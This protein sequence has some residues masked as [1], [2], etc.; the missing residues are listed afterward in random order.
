MGKKRRRHAARR[1]RKESSVIVIYKFAIYL[2]LV[3]V[4]GGFLLKVATPIISNTA[5]VLGISLLAK[6]GD[7]DSSGSGSS[8]DDS[9]S[10]S[11]SSGSNSD[12]GSS[13][14]GSSSNSSGPSSSQESDS[15]KIE[16]RTTTSA[17]SNED[18][19]RRTLV[20]TK[21]DETRT[22]IRLS[23]EER[24]R[25]RTKDGRTRIDITSGGIKTRL[26][27]RDD[28]VVIKV[29][30]EDGTE[31][32]LEASTILKID[33]R[34]GSSGI[35]IA[36]SGAEKLILQRGNAGAVT[37]FPLSIDLAT[38][39]LTINTASG[40]REVA[41]LPDQAVQNLLAA[42]VLSQLVRS[43]ATLAGEEITGLED[44]IALGEKNGIPVYQIQGVSEQRLLGFIPVL[45]E[46]T[47][48]VSAETGEVAGTQ[49]SVVDRVLDAVSL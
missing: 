26:E 11:G 10:G 3:V 37:D 41:V 40:E 45:I 17:S 4:I 49:Q 14:S 9:D 48:T 46:K 34:L 29:E 19:E 6:G 12:S 27:N 33:D 5:S 18:E 47:V 43:N 31:E 8:N 44:V 21:A 35:K 15:T 42:N 2:F 23:E 16:T 28:R 24:I 7:D 13:S 39:T 36:T 38:N 20:E 30:Q 22:E 1:S 32:E 25:A